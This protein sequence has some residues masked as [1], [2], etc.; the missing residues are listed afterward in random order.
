MY[1]VEN[2]LEPCLNPK[3][4]EQLL[5]AV[6]HCLINIFTGPFH[7]GG[8]SYIRNLSTRHVVETRTH[9]LGSN[10]NKCK[11]YKLHRLTLVGLGEAVI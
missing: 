1:L 5:S 10:C 11:I 6:R 4:E 2:F 9:L 7:I 8:G 3:L